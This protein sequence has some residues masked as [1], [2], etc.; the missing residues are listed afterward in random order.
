MPRKQIVA[1][2]LAIPATVAITDALPV[3]LE[4]EFEFGL[5]LIITSLEAARTDEARD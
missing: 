5:R 3:T 4:D 2:A 1:A